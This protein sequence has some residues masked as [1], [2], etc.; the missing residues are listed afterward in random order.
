FRPERRVGHF[1]V[2]RGRLTVDDGTLFQRS[3][4]EV[5]RMFQHAAELG[6][7]LYSWARERI[8]EALPALIAARGDPEV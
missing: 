1:K 4:A 3:P 8:S 6:V 7:P 5:V 2:F